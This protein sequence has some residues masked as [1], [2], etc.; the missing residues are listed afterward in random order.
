MILNFNDY[1]RPD[2]II[3]FFTDKYG[4]KINEFWN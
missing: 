2:R 3:D 4:D 1:K